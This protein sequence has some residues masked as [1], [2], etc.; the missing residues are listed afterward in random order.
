MYY[1]FPVVL[2]AVSGSLCGLGCP[3]LVIPL[4]H[5]T[6]QVQGLQV[7]TTTVPTLQFLSLLRHCGQTQ[8]F[9][10]ARQVLLPLTY[11][12]DL[13]YITRRMKNRT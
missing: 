7:C 4:P 9:M 12:R 10:D 3:Q 6:P 1:A 2:L 5:P 11:I 13:K 8:G